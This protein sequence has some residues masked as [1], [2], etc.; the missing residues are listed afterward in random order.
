MITS[1]STGRQFLYLTLLLSNGIGPVAVDRIIRNVHATDITEE[2]LGE[3]FIQGIIPSRI[4]LSPLHFRS[5]ADALDGG[6]LRTFHNLLVNGQRI[7]CPFDSVL[8]DHFWE[9]AHAHKLPKIFVAAG[10]APPVDAPWQAIIGSRAADAAGI[11]RAARAAIDNAQR[12]GVTVSGGAAGVDTTALRA[13][14]DA[15][16]WTVNVPSA[17]LPTD[18]KPRPRELHISPYPPM[19]TFAPGLAM[20]R[21]AI[22]VALANDITVAHLAPRQDGRPSGTVD[23][24]KRAKV[25]G[26]PVKVEE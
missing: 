9:R 4:G 5:V 18:I 1:S 14:H 19:T 7:I 10:E 22:I 12:G 21:N 15:G 13:A 24:I 11:E 3:F 20:A 8:P 16:G 26:V 23:A 25:I 6:A 17:S 2:E